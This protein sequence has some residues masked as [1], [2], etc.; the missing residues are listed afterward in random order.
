[1]LLINECEKEHIYFA[2]KYLHVVLILGWE[3]SE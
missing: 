2:R 1:M 3:V